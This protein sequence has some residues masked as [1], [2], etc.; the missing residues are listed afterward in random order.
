M[1]WIFE[2]LQVIIFVGSAIAWWLTQSK[3]GGDE[4]T[5]TPGDRPGRQKIDVDQLERNRR[6]REEIRRKRADRQRQQRG[7]LEPRPE[8]TTTARRSTLPE[9][10]E[11]PEIPRL[12]R[13]V[14]EQMPPVLREMMGIPEPEPPPPAPPPVPEPNPV[15]ERQERLQ[16]EM[17]ELEAKRREAKAMAKKAQRPGVTRRRRPA[18][19]SLSERDFLATL[20]DPQQARRAIVLREILGKPVGLS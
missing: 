7:T 16:A 11:L 17:A 12:D 15:L 4:E 10:P 5:P 20:R 8:E 3:K 14:A 1:D 18:S 9:L 19:T 2:N 6:L 13:E